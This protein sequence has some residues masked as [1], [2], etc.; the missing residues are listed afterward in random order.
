MRIPGPFPGQALPPRPGL[1]VNHGQGL[2]PRPGLPVNPEL[3]PR[4]RFV[5]PQYCRNRICGVFWM[6][7]GKSNPRSLV[8]DHIHQCSNQ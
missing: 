6:S 4:V 3:A 8:S 2:P 5:S 1:P 7:Y